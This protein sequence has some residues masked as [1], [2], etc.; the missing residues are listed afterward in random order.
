[1]VLDTVLPDE[2]YPSRTCARTKGS[3]VRYSYLIP[4]SL[5]GQWRYEDRFKWRLTLTA[6]RG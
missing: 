3:F 4:A 1:M 6:V 5:L 2:E